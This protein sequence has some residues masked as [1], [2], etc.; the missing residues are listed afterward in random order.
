[1]ILLHW[2]DYFVFSCFILASLLIGVY[3]A[4]SAK[5][6]HSTGEFISG[7]GSMPLIPTMLSLVVSY[8]SAII[9][10]GNY[11]YV[12]VSQKYY[13]NRANSVGFLETNI[14]HIVTFS[15]LF[16]RL[17]IYHVILMK[18]VLFTESMQCHNN[19]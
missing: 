2:A 17:L 7:G 19:L 13:K 5:R 4:C 18:L 14:S 16:N 10:L 3:V 12:E 6:G 8:I 1:M 9:I 11:H 15:C